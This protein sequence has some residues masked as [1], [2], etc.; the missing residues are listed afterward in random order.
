MYKNRFR[1]NSAPVEL[2]GTSGNELGP[3]LDSLGY[4]PADRPS[5]ATASALK[6]AIQMP[7]MHPTYLNRAARHA[8]PYRCVSAEMTLRNSTNMRHNEARGQKYGDLVPLSPSQRKR[9]LRH[10]FAQK[11]YR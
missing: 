9:F 7:L 3:S 1:M 10:K 5:P 8:I 11:S 6:R 4:Y 2:R